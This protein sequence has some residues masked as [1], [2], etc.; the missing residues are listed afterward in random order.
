LLNLDTL[1]HTLYAALDDPAPWSAACKALA[2]SGVAHSI[3]AQRSGSLLGEYCA[4]GQADS[5]ATET[6]LRIVCQ[7]AVEWRLHWARPQQVPGSLATLKQ[8]LAPHLCR[9]AT[10]A[11]RLG[12]SAQRISDLAQAVQSVET[13]ILFINA[14][15]QVLVANN[16]ARTLLLES[17]PDQAD[18]PNKAL[19]M[20][21]R[22]ALTDNLAQHRRIEN[23]TGTTFF[24]IAPLANAQAMP[25]TMLVVTENTSMGRIATLAQLAYLFGLSHAE[26]VVTQLLALGNTPEEIAAL[27]DVRLSTIRSQLSGILAKTGVRNQSALIRLVSLVP[28]I[29]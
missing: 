6:V 10:L 26:S 11:D 25:D 19:A 12:Q 8:Q 18:S 1:L 14:A 4:A 24:S 28:A 16:K 5:C 23:G 13:G 20:A 3:S 7:N 21:M 27:R 15:G 22:Q 29:R 17:Q 2:T 9:I